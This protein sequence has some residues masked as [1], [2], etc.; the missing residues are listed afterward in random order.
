M[1]TMENK[2]NVKVGQIWRDNDVRY[3]S[4][5]IRDLEV[6]E[7]SETHAKCKNTETGKISEIRLNRFRPN[8]TGYR[9]VKDVEAKRKK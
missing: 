6:L 5:R 7:V 9:L 3:Y 2:F 4:D 1:K 8:S